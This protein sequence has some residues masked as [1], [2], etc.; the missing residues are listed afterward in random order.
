MDSEQGSN[1]ESNHKLMED[2]GW[3]PEHPSGIPGLRFLH[4]T[5]ALHYCAQDVFDVRK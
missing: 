2:V 3:D 4:P 1:L 5:S